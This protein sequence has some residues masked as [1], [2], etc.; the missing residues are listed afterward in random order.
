[1]LEKLSANQRLMLAVA[2]SVIFFVGYTAIV[3]PIE[4]ENKVI[5][6]KSIQNNS[7]ASQMQSSSNMQDIITHDI[8]EKEKYGSDDKSVIVTVTNKDYILKVDTLGRISSKEL[9]QDKFKTKED[10]HAQLI[11]TTGMKPLFLRFLDEAL[12][13]EAMSVAYTA[14][15]R[16]L[17]L[18]GVAKKVILTQ[19]LS[20]LTVTKELTFYDDGHYDAKVSLSQD[21][22]Y[23]IYLGQRP[24]VNETEQMMTVTGAMIFTD[25]EIATII[26]DGDAEGRKT[27]SGVELVSAFDQYSATIMYGFAKDTNIIVERD[28][29]DNPV[30]YFDALQIMA[31]S[32]Y[33]G[34]KEY[35]VLKNI[36][37]I[38]TN[39]IEYGWFTF[40]SRPLFQLL[41]WLHGI[42][43]NWGWSIIALTLMIRAVLYPLTYKGM[44]SMQKIKAISPQIKEIQA[45]YKS[46]P[47]RMNKAVMDMYKKHNANPLGGCLPML[48]QIPVFFAI[49]RVLLNAV[50]LQGAP[51]IMWVT[52]LSRM[53]E[54]YVLPILMGASMFYQQRLTPTNFTDPIQEKVFK[55]LPVIFTFFFLTFPSG[56]VLYWF[57]N[58]IFSIMQQF[59]VNTQFKNAQDA[60]IALSKHAIKEEHKEEVKAKQLE[61]KSGKNDD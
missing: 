50:E 42:F 13:S 40:A 51:W 45:K 53:D 19:K 31:F 16:E 4:P 23:F 39:A 56:L 9:L 32:G 26:E 35:K 46:D 3:P 2:L 57:V 29:D 11:S 18:D 27:F 36:K 17:T 34:Q 24:K 21:K 6:A 60:Q 48:L 61:K 25:D 15:V 7:S 55:Y 20:T 5:D 14:D 41:S 33:V 59:V 12:N 47:Q 58:N 1:M 43:G 30:V 38:L 52:D 8:S 37:P 44:M 54:F 22:R 28:R 49:Y 10:Q